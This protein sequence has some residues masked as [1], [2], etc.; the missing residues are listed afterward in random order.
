MSAARL[1]NVSPLAGVS[2]RMISLEPPLVGLVTIPLKAIRGLFKAAS[3]N[4]VC[5]S[6][7]AFLRRSS[8]LSL[9]TVTAV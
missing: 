3:G 7:S 2:V 9:G 1:P 8:C 4:A 5:E 6:L